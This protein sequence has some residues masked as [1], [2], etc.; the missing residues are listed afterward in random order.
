MNHLIAPLQLE[1]QGVAISR[2]NLIKHIP[3]FLPCQKIHGKVRVAK[4]GMGSSAAL[5]TSLVGAFCVFF[6]IVASLPTREDRIRAEYTS[7]HDVI[8]NLAQICH[9]IAQG[10]IGSGFDVSSAVFGSQEYIRFS[11]DIIQDII[12]T[13][14]EFLSSETLLHC[15]YDETNQWDAVVVRFV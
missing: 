6:K 13:K 5:I 8:H 7:S 2:R 15:I 4:T 14:P 9:C 1:K 10:K 3:P 11:S 12:N